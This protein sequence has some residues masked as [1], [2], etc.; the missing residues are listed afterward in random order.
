MKTTLNL[1]DPIMAQARQFADQQGLTLKEVFIRALQALMVQEK[2]AEKPYVMVD[3]RVHGQ[4]L[5]PEYA[6]ADWPTLRALI[7]E[8]H[9]G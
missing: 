2:A 6:N 3:A 1:P 9:G 5:N 7:Y 8:G 4:G